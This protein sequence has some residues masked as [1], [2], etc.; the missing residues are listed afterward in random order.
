ML[1]DAKQIIARIG[2]T[3]QMYL[4]GNTPDLA[5]ERADLRLALVTL[6]RVRQEQLHFLQEAI[7]LLEQGRIEF[8]EIPLR[9][10]LDLSLLLAKAYMLYFEIT[11]EQ[12]F[13][14]ITQQILKPL[15]VHEHG[16]VYFFLAYASVCK[17]DTA[18]SRHW[19]KKYSQTPEFDAFL[20]QQHSAF[21]PYRETLW[22][23][24]LT[25]PKP[26]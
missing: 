22:F 13:A 8:E 20:L 12:R 6:S 4:E 7:V 17:N 26:H 5:L 2:E 14:L 1:K 10:Y 9:T 3:D 11:K 15:T 18:L 16:D 25:Q 19:L 24:Q 23:I 21:A